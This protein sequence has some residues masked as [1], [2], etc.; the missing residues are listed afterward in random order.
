VST[1]P[2][3]TQFAGRRCYGGLDLASVSDLCAWVML[4]ECQEVPD[5]VDVLARFWIPAALLDHGE[6]RHLYQPWVDQ[7]WLQ[8]T[9]GEAIDY[10]YIVKQVV[11]DAERFNLVEV[12]VDRLFE[13]RSVGSDLADHGIEVFPMNQTT[14]DYA[15]PTADLERRLKAHGVHH[16]GNPILRWKVDG[17]E[18]TAD[19]EGRMKPDRKRARERKVKIDGLMALLMA[20]DRL[21]RSDGPS[22]YE[23]DGVFVV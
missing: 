1:P 8:T 21:M 23:E 16:G 7:G 10:G 6:L 15:A 4:F 20:N 19:S 13:G 22:V 12:N 11:E 9:P 5:A 14:A 3:E 2:D 18:V 17:A